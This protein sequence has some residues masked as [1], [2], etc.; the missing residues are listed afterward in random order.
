MG[1]L[2]AVLSLIGI[3]LYPIFIKKVIGRLEEY[4]CMLFNQLLLAVALAITAVFTL[5]ITMPSDLVIVLLIFAAIIN[6][7]AIYLYYKA[8]NAGHTSI[9]VPI[10]ATSGIATIFI[11]YMLFAEPVYPLN[12][13]GIAMVIL[14]IFLAAIDKFER[15]KKWDEHALHAF[16]SSKVW[17]PAAGLAI[18]AA[19][20]GVF[21][22]TLIKYSALSIGLHKSLVYV[23]VLTLLFL[24]FAFLAKPVRELITIPKIDEW[25][26]ILLSGAAFVM[27]AVCFYF[28]VTKI[29]VSRA[30]TVTSFAPLAAVMMSAIVLKERLKV[31]QYIGLAILMAGT[32]LLTS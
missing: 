5:R 25:Q 11:N 22:S 2:L 29:M 27:G 19:L 10:A 7:F 12:F 26:W 1:I 13:L 6:T 32:V 30:N 9:V 18:L 3:G 21:T 31:R 17:Q 24:L 16:F 4:T 23:Q 28:A 20:C 8:I 14:G 15:P